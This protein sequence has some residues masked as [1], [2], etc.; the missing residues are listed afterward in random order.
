VRFTALLH[1]IYDRER[2]KAAYY[3]LKRD[4]APGVDGETW[5]HYGEALEANLGPLRPAEAGAY[6]AEPVKR[7]YI[8][9]TDG[10]QR[11]LGTPDKAI[12]SD[13]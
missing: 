11:P 1:H 8:A 2:L 5:R 4:A 9:K 3:A 6:R 7:A 10:R 12:P 13:P